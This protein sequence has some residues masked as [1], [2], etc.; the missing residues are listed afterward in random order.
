M[1]QPKLLPELTKWCHA[2]LNRI[3][4][5]TSTRFYKANDPQDGATINTRNCMLLIIQ[6]MREE[7]YLVSEDI[8]HVIT[9]DEA[10]ELVRVLDKRLQTEVPQ[11]YWQL[12]MKSYR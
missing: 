7:I 3:I 4:E 8:H 1:T 5:M 6:N 12:S 9:L 11:G 10:N 2:E